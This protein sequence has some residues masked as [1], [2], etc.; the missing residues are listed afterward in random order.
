VTRVYR[1]G[2]GPDHPLNFGC[3]VFSEVLLGTSATLVA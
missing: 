1:F 3:Y 2:Y